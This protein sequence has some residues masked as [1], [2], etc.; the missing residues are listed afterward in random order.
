MAMHSAGGIGRWVGILAAALAAAAGLSCNR[1]GNDEPGSAGGGGDKVVLYCSVDEAVAQGVVAEFEALTGNRVLVRYDTE[2]SKTVGLVQ[3]LRAEAPAPAAD[4]FWSGEVFHTIRLA[5]EGLLAPYHDDQTRHWP[6]RYADPQGRWYGLALRARVIC[7]NTNRL[8]AAEA[9]RSLEDLLK[10]Q[11]KGR[12]VMARPA[13]GTTGGDVASWFAHYGPEKARE[14]LRG[15]ADNEVRQVDGNSTSARMVGTGQAD[16]GLT[17]T[18]D[19]YAGQ[20]NNWPIAMHYLDQG[21]EGVLTI[22]NTVALVQGAPHPALAK[23][24]MAFLLSPKV[25]RMLA[26]TYSRNTPVRPAVAEGLDCPRIPKPLE[27]DYAKVADR[28][29]EAIEAAEELLP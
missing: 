14:I 8:T 24:L 11:W 23:Q 1:D 18:D 20:R 17:D 21:G 13:F 28:L 3:R 29:T 10:S 27:V 5:E 12:I 16:V 15:L 25:E 26:Q 7:Y 4:V 22:P 19:V 6:A 9:P 2:A